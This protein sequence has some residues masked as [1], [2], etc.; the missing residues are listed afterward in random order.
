MVVLG[1]IGGLNSSFVYGITRRRRRMNGTAY[2]IDRMRGKNTM[3]H[4]VEFTA[5][6]PGCCSKLGVE[7]STVFV[8]VFTQKPESWPGSWIIRSFGSDINPT[9]LES[10]FRIQA[11]R[12]KLFVYILICKIFP[13]GYYVEVSPGYK[14]IGQAVGIVLHLIVVPA[15]SGRNPSL[16]MPLA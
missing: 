11:G 2:V 14:R 1:N 6:R 12:G 3:F 9:I 13:F 10:E 4:D 16:V 5:S 8:D 7:E 15:S